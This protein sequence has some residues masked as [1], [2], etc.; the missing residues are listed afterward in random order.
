MPS[1]P[2]NPRNL[3]SIEGSPGNASGMQR[4]PVLA[5]V[6]LSLS[7]HPYA[8]EALEKGGPFVVPSITSYPLSVLVPRVFPHAAAV[9]PALRLC[10]TAVLSGHRAE[11]GTRANS[12]YSYSSSY[13]SFRRRR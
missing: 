6:F 9:I 10:V 11:T 3:L 5:G 4:T 7:M 1:F 13:T 8:K 12:F 2:T